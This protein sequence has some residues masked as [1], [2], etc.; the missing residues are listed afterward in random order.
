VLQRLA[1]A[2]GQNGFDALASVAVQSR[3]EGLVED[4]ALLD[5]AAVVG[6]LAPAYTGGPFTYASQHQV[7]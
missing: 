1:S 2:A 6:G 5:V 3:R 7:D 4:P